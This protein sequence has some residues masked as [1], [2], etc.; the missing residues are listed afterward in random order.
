[1][2]EAAQSGDRRAQG[3]AETALAEVYDNIG[4]TE[5]ARERFFHAE[6]LLAAWPQDLAFTYLKHALFILDLGTEGDLRA[7]LQYLAAATEQAERA[8]A[9]GNA[10]VASVLFAVHLNRADALA[11]LGDLAG[12]A[13]ELEITAPDEASGRKLDLVRG[14]VAARRGDL[15]SAEELF[16]A[17][18]DGALKLDYRWRVAME[19]GELHRSAGRMQDAERAFRDAVAT[20][21]ELRRAAGEIE[22]RP[23]VLARRTLP[24]AGL[25]QVLVAQGRGADAL[26]V[27]ESLHARTWLDVVLGRNG[28][29]ASTTAQVLLDARLRQQVAAG[30]ALDGAA[31]LARVGDREVLVFLSVGPTTWRAHAAHGQVEF[32]PLSPS[33]LEAV[34]AFRRTPPDP[35]AAELA[36]A[37]LIPPAVAAG[38]QPLYIVASGPLADLSFAALRRGGHFLIDDRPVARLPGLA[39]LACGQNPWSDRQVFVGDSLGD[40]REAAAE[41][42]QLGGPSAHVGAAATRAVVESARNAALLHLAVHGRLTAAGGALDLADGP[43]TAASVLDAGIAPRVVILTGCAT[44]ASNDAEAWGGF[45]S[46]FL[47]AG[48]RHVVATLHSVTDADAAAFARAYY[49]EPAALGPVARL[50]AA[51]RALAKDRPVA[52]WASFAVWGD[53]DCDGDAR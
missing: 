11:Q 31:L 8:A 51:Q 36:G 29:V 49:H 44:A 32:A 40:L 47:A 14:Y 6:E 24:Y 53:A 7:A 27:A 4:M 10:D 43:F 25:F 37:A 12:A 33:D 9:G 1:M 38:D 52:A 35:R 20:V 22:L 3:G 26:A 17:A 5:L 28:R 15:R 13:R 30:P 2:S 39:A 21:E 46:A 42:R 23:W 19:I 50:A 48:S 18:N 45:P 34:A 16:A 41:V